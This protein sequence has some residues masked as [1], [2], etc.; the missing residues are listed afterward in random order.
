MLVGTV[1]FLPP[2]PALRAPKAAW[3]ARRSTGR[4]RRAAVPVR[5]V[6]APR[7]QAAAELGAEELL[8]ANAAFYEAMRAQSHE[9]MM[10]LW[11]PASDEVSVAHPLHGLVVGGA[12]VA[13]AWAGMF[14]LGKMTDLEVEVVRTEVG[15]NVGWLLCRQ[16]VQGV[17][18]RE[19]VGGERVATNIFH[20]YKGEWKMAH[21]SA[22]PVVMMEDE[23]GAD[24]SGEEGGDSSGPGADGPS[25]VGGGGTGVA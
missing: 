6:A 16:K 18:G 8:A 12:E 11:M 19:T 20:V 9:R 24:G 13:S 3:R 2:L 14:A 1:A 10:D 7:A 25:G 22:A 21:H 23:S 4:P 17:R 5:W 15:R